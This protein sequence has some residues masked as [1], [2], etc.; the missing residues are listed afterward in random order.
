MSEV[1]PA[2]R[3]RQGAYLFVRKGSRRVNLDEILPERPARP[4]SVAEL[5]TPRDGAGGLR[6]RRPPL[7][8][9][10]LDPR[11]SFF[12]HPEA[13]VCDLYRTTAA[14]LRR[15][16]EGV[17]I[18][19]ITSPHGRAGRTLTT[20][21]LAS[22]LAE[23]DRVC[24]VDLHR[25]NPGIARAFGLTDPAGLLAAARARRRAPGAP[26]DVTLLA[27]RLTALCIEPDA[28][29]DALALAT[30]RSILDTLAEHADH[31]LIDGPPVLDGDPVLDLAALVDG[32]LLVAEPADLASGDYERTLALFEGRRLVGTLLNDRGARTLTARTR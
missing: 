15:R 12:V 5:L 13:P 22:A 16:A 10:A 19:L 6:Y 4:A 21:N 26:L 31:V 27:D 28:R 14:D 3:R 32:V 25:R 11:L 1:S 2:A 18:V 20:L 8:P 30:L 24:V 23:Q 17:R 29:A 9:A 7:D